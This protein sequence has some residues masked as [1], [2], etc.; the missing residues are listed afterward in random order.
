MESEQLSDVLEPEPL[1]V[2][3]EF[4]QLSAGEMDASEMRSQS[5]SLRRLLEVAAAAAA[6]CSQASQ[7]YVVE[8]QECATCS[9]QH[10]EVAY[11]GAVM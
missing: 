6:T 7:Q 4:E 1:V 5:E 11:A 10:L 9:E 8:D 3:V 2:V